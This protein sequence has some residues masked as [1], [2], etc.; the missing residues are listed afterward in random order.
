MHMERAR[1]PPSSHK[2]EMPLLS[3]FSSVKPELSGPDAFR[4]FAAERLDIDQKLENTN[5]EN[6]EGDVV[7]DQLEHLADSTMKSIEQEQLQAADAIARI[8]VP[9]MDFSVLEKEWT[10]L[11]S[12]ASAIFRWIQAS[13]ED[14]FSLPRWPRDKLTE[15]KL[16]WR[17]VSSTDN[18]VSVLEKIEASKALIHPFIEAPDVNNIASS[19]DCVQRRDRLAILE[20]LDEDENI[21]PLLMKAKP[22]SNLV[23]MVKKR[24]ANIADT[25]SKRQR[26]A[27]KKPLANQ[28]S[29]VYSTHKVPT[30]EPRDSEKGERQILFLGNSPRMSV[31]L[32]DHFIGLRA[33]KWTTSK[34]FQTQEVKKDSVSI[35]PSSPESSE[36]NHGSHKSKILVETTT[37]PK[38]VSRAP[39]PSVNLPSAPLTAFISLSIPRYLIGALE[40]LIPSLTLIER[41]YRAH[42]TSV[43]SPGSVFRSEV[44]PPLAFDADITMS[45]TTGLIVTSMI[46]IRQKPRPGLL[47]SSIQ[48]RIEKVSLR[49]ERIIILVGGEGGEDDTLR[50][51]SASDSIALTEIQGFVSGLACNNIVYYVGGGDDTLSRWAASMVCRYAQVDH[52]QMQKG[53]LEDETLW[54]LFLRRAGLNVFAAQVV[55]GQLKVPRSEEGDTGSARH[56]L[57]AF[58]TMTRAERRERFG[59]LVGLRVLERVSQ[60][61]DEMWNKG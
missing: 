29:G 59:Q 5:M 12:S 57:A 37:P 40:R 16:I 44:V 39:Y 49:Y 2:I 42:N 53:L 25:V 48:E 26:L 17:P 13:N 60:M 50:E 43:W 47:K 61:V 3:G 20:Q 58:V 56:G 52:P 10:R 36:R 1:E 51:I 32:L 7:E 11:R 45:P 41:D 46:L 4:R 55:A 28:T 30:Q 22:R 18:S 9:V 15:S 24:G 8:P 6:F 54:E 35:L 33:P 14:I 38:P 27:A 19:A 34:F 21:E 23:E 31:K